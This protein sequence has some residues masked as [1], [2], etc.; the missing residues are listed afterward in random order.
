M[1][2]P[3]VPVNNDMS[4]SSL[5]QLAASDRLTGRNFINITHTDTYP[6]IDPLTEYNHSNHYVFITGA[7]KGLGRATAISFAKAGVAGIGMGARSGLDAVEKDIVSAAQ[8]AG[9]EPPKLLKLKLDVTSWSDVEA[10]ANA[11]EKAFGRL[12]ILINNAGYLSAFQLIDETDRDEYWKNYEVN[13]KGTY[14]MSKAFVPLLL[15]GGQKQIINLS[16]AGAHA[17]RQGASGYQTTK[18]AI[19][20]FSEHLMAD[21]GDQGLLSYSVHPGGVPTE[22]GLTMPKELHASKNSKREYVGQKF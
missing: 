21:Y 22:M 18:F 19:L 4:L 20:R 9:K 10:A 2:Y 1:P 15:K 17:I 12:D 13:V 14:L 3:P 8:A 16:S 11:T 6:S 5:L 7:S